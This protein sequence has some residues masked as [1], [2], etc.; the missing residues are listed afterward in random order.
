MAYKSRLTEKTLTVK[1]PAGAS[2]TVLWRAPFPCKV[3]AVWAYRLGG[4]GAVVN[5]NKNGAKLAGDVSL[6]APGAWTAGTLNAAAVL[7]IAAGDTLTA[8]VISVAG[9]PTDVAVQVDI[10]R[11]ADA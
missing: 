7:T 9:S 11:N 2:S 1:A 3:K 5:V 4:T 6:T 10:E 8:E